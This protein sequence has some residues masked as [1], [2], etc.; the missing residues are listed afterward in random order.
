M[1]RCCP[2]PYPVIAYQLEIRRHSTTYLFGI[3][4]PMILTTFAGF[5]A[6]AVVHE[7]PLGV[8]TSKCCYRRGPA[9]G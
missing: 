4:L 9:Q 5:L 3:L 7:S 6:F 8:E 1:H 2:E